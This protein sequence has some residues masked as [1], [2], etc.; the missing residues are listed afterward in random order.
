MITSNFFTPMHASTFF[1]PGKTDY[2][3]QLSLPD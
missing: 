3:Y 2:S 1:L